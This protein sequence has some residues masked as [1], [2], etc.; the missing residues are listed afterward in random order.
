MNDEAKKMHLEKINAFFGEIKAKL[1][2]QKIALSNIENE[3]HILFSQNFKLS[4]IKLKP[5][6]PSCVM[7]V[8]PSESTI[9]KI[10]S[11]I[12]NEEGIKVV[13]EL[14]KK[15]A[16]WIIEID[17]RLFDSKYVDLSSNELTALLLHEVGHTV[18]SNAVVSRLS[19][20]LKF[21]YARVT[22]PVKEVFRKTKLGSLVSLAVMDACAFSRHNSQ[23]DISKEIEADKLAIKLGYKESLNTALSKFIQ[24]KTNSELSQ[25]EENARK[26]L[27]FSVEIINQLKRRE[28]KSAKSKL[29]KLRDRMGNSITAN[30]INAIISNS[31]G[32]NE[33]IGESAH[34]NIICDRV[35]EIMDSYYTEFFIFGPKKLPKLE[36]YTLDYIEVEKQKMKTQDDKLLLISYIHSKID[37]CQ[38]YINILNSPKYSKKYAVPHPKEYIVNYLNRLY[39]L[40]KEVLEYPIEEKRY[41]LSIQFPP[42]YEG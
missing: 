32:E 5:S 23:Y 27:G 30:K 24:N 26:T 17:S 33:F 42:G 10:V 22:A 38:Y 8:Y 19:N 25:S 13:N 35:N 11:S 29:E 18:A 12:V 4:I 20:V 7:S 40:R 28:A 37:T 31:I 34:M 39:S 1:S 41:G 15:N 36:Q 3:L 21:S 16:D 14:W 2:N 6:D 9:D